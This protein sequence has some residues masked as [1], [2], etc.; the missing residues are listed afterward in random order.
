MMI[1]SLMAMR[2]KPRTDKH[3]VSILLKTIFDDDKACRVHK[4]IFFLRII[5]V[6]TV[7]ISAVIIELT[8][9]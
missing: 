5:K 9:M 7:E 3:S 2:N 1:L 8:I 4:G 6:I